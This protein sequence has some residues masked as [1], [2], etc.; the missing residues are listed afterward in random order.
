[1]ASVITS[2]PGDSVKVRPIRRKNR[3]DDH[4]PLA[5]N[6]DHIP[7]EGNANPQ[8]HQEQRCSLHQRLSES[9]GTTKRAVPKGRVSFD[10]IDLEEQEHHRPH[11]ERRQRGNDRK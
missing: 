11:P 5:A 8:S 7:A 4:L 9:I 3:A 1:M 2:Q 10:G 6:I